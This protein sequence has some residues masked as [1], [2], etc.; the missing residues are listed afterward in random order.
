LSES[1]LVLP[2]CTALQ[3]SEIY[4]SVFG[5]QENKVAI[6]MAVDH[7]RFLSETG[8]DISAELEFISSHFRDVS[9]Q[10][11]ALRGLPVSV[12]YAIL[13]HRPLPLESED[14]LYEFNGKGGEF[15]ALM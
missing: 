5:Q 7:L 14:D 3:N 4:G 11:D 6:E 13:C 9:G 12:I 2:V 10:T 15:F 8:C 1:R